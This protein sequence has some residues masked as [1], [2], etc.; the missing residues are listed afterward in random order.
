MHFVH[1][2]LYTG[3]AI[4]SI[5]L[6]EDVLTRLP[7]LTVRVLQS[8]LEHPKNIFV[9]VLDVLQL[10]MRYK[11]LPL[12]CPCKNIDESSLYLFILLNIVW[13]K[14]RIKRG[15]DCKRKRQV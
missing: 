11:L 4:P 5:N 9:R 14:I 6:E 13:I 3:K 10:L 7:D 15:Q 8:V 12:A 1:H 2:W